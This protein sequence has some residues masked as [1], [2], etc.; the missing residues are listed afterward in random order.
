MEWLKLIG[1]VIVILGFA[2]K[3]DTILTVVLAGIVTGLVAGM[4]PVE[5]LNT[6]GNS[7]ISNRLATIFV[8]TLPVIGICERYG[9]KQKAVDLIKKI[10]QASAGR[11]LTAYTV[12]RAVS[13]ALSLRMSGHPM[14]VRPLIE[15]M[16]EAAAEA[17]YGKLEEADVETIKGHSAAADNY[18]NFFGQNVFMGSAGVLSVVALFNGLGYEVSPLRLS[19]WTIPITVAACVLAGIDNVILDKR[20]EKKYKA[21]LNAAPKERK[22]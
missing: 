21:R 15:P 17:K 19:L 13:A 10:A 2:L 22:D 11:I 7:F 18:G 9:M 8:L 1:I 3:F 6:L 14:F 16:A 4:T 5:I 20:L 12:L